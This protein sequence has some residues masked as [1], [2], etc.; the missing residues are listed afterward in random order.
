MFSGEHAPEPPKVT[1]VSYTVPSPYFQVYS[2]LSLYVLG[3]GAVIHFFVS[4]RARFSVGN[5]KT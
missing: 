3:L 1:G 2:T 5:S 4:K